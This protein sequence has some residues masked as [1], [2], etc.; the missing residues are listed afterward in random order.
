MEE[1]AVPPRLSRKR[2]PASGPRTC[3]GGQSQTPERLR[4]DWRRASRHVVAWLTF[5]PELAKPAGLPSPMLFTS[6]DTRRATLRLR[7]MVLRR[8]Q[9]ET[10]W[11]SWFPG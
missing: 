10:W 5:A 9:P 11:S 8:Q 6:R 2:A 3:V 4:R 7:S 1:Q